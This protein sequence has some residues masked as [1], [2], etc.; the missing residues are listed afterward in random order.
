MSILDQ[1]RE[2]AHEGTHC[3]EAGEFDRFGRLLHEG[4]VLKTQMA[5]RDHGQRHRR[6]L[7]GGAGGRG[8]GG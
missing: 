1:L 8:P 5:G 6:D 2:L 7:R 4:W 3:L